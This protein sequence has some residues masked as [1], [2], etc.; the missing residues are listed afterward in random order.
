[1]Q[2]VA[3]GYQAGVG[4]NTCG[5]ILQKS[6]PY[7]I[8]DSIAHKLK[9]VCHDLYGW[10]GLHHGDY[11]EMH[12]EEKS[13]VLPK[14][15]LSPREIWVKFGTLVARE[16]YHSTWIDYL[17]KNYENKHV[18]TLI[19]TDLRFLDEFEILKERGTFCVLVKSPERVED[20]EII[21]IAENPEMENM[22]WDYTIRN[23]GSIGDLR[24]KISDLLKVIN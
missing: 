16:V 11:Y 12:R 21:R 2:I 6:I 18:N 7:S 24:N 8:L 15:G 3:F 14:I 19:L 4:K 13:I 5:E 23:D 10:A 20:N 9:D 22:P 1:M 17:I